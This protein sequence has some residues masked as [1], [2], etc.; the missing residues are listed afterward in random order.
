MVKLEVGQRLKSKSF[1]YFTVEKLV[2]SGEVHFRFE[3]SGGVGKATSGNVRNGLV[4]DNFAKTVY[5]V[6]Y[7][8]DGIFK[9]RLPNNGPCTKEYA[10]WS[11]IMFRCYGDNR[12]ECTLRNYGDCSVVAE[13]HN[14]Q[15]FASWC[16]TQPEMNFCNSSIEKDIIIKGNKLYSPNTT[17]FVPIELNVAITGIKHQNSTGKAGVWKFNDSYIS[18]VTMF[19][20]K[21][22]LGRF[23][24]FQDA[25][26]VYREVKQSYIRALAEIYKDRLRADVYEKLKEWVI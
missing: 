16:Q 13:W 8:G 19:S 23:D 15:T 2:N 21:A 25:E 18:E 1:G 22:S 24:N 11:A 4:R 12:D 26:Y 14:Y 17:C 7:F 3:E 5:G 10:T 6:G 20:T 9:S